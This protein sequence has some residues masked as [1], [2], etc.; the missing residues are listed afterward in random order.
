MLY[1]HFLNYL[2]DPAVQYDPR[3][4]KLNGNA[5]TFEL[6][7]LPLRMLSELYVSVRDNIHS[8]NVTDDKLETCFV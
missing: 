4:Y 7:L 8:E 3:T 6:E 5:D 2:V 1:R